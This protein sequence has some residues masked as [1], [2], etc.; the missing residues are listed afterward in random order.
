MGAAVATRL[1]DHGW[2]V[3]VCDRDPDAV[4]E[5]VQRGATCVDTPAALAVRCDH[6]LVFVA[7]DDQVFS[8]VDGPTGVLCSAPSDSVVI[9]HSTVH[10]RTC[11][12]LAKEAEGLS[13]H[14]LDA[15][16]SGGPAGAATGTLTALVGGDEVTADLAASIFAAYSGR[17]L[18][19]G[20]VGAGQIVK[21]TNTV[22]SLGNTAIALEGLRLAGQWGIDEATMRDIALHSSGASRALETWES[23]SAL[24]SPT[25][26]AALRPLALKDLDL[27]LALASDVGAE[28][29]LSALVR[30]ALAAP[31]DD[32]GPG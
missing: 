11:R 22:M 15:P 25:A 4:E 19:V 32:G 29:P 28:V 12:E 27:V 6:V 9:V 18:H 3:V 30:S 8:V 2:D 20:G 26:G 24:A 23:R 16:V 5:V 17:V 14:L 31:S 10:P 1:L 7:D 21:L 13:V